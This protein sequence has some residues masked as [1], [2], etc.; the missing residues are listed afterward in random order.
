MRVKLI[1]PQFRID[2]RS[3]FFKGQL[4]NSNGLDAGVLLKEKLRLTVGYY[5]LTDNLDTYKKN[6]D[7]IDIERNLQLKYGSINTEVIYKNTRFISLGMPLDFAF[8]KNT[9]Q[10]KN[11]ATGEVQ[12]TASG[13]IFLTDF[14]LSA[15]LKP[16]RWIGVKGILGYRKTIYNGVKDFK[17][18]GIFTSI[19][20]S[21]D[22]REIIKDVQ[23]FQLKKKYKGNRNS[24]ETAV[25]LITD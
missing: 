18:D 7:N 16:T 11:S 17:L 3:I 25:D 21:I 23:M 1:R 13:I 2:N 4:L 5:W 19:G 6:V 24:I 8:G 10:Y 9:L 15:T 20:L 12:S 22:I 14:G